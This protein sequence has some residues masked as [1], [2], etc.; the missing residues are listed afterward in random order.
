MA[1]TN[2]SNAIL[3]LDGLKIKMYKIEQIENYSPIKFSYIT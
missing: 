3:K 1:F 2:A